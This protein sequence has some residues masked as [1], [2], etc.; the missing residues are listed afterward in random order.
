LEA[1]IERY[2]A[3][4]EFL[5]DS[6]LDLNSEI[7]ELNLVIIE[8]D[9]IIKSLK[10]K[11]NTKLRDF[12]ELEGKIAE[13][14]GLTNDQSIQ[15][16]SLEAE[17]TR[18]LK[19]LEEMESLKGVAEN[20]KS[21]LEIVE[22]QSLELIKEKKKRLAIEDITNNTV[23][24]YLSVKIGSKPK[25]GNISKVKDGSGKW[26]YTDFEF[27]MAHGKDTEMLKNENFVLKIIDTDINKVLPYLEENP[28]YP[29][30]QAGTSGINFSFN[31][32]T[33]NVLHINTQLKNGKNYEARIYYVKNGEE[34]LLANSH[35]LLV[36]NGK[37]V[38]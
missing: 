6:I 30:S 21:Q 9:N 19:E 15:I 24:N 33:I 16:A 13:L 20:R 7:R 18:I 34:Y 22:V 35:R 3:E 26:M 10:N 11:L 28:S 36:S 5:V 29:E 4:N 8:Q 12:N 37:V 23:V 14:R 32:N 17:K 25:K 31:N 27:V 1:I 2:R 38:N